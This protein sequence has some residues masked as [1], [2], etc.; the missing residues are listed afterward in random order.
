MVEGFSQDEYIR[1][2]RQ[3]ILPQVGVEGQRKLKEAS[4][5][6]VGAGG[7]G[8]PISLYLAAAGIGRIGLVDPDRVDE[9]NLQRQV[10]YESGMVGQPKVEA[11]RARLIDLNPHCQ[12][13]VF[14]TTFTSATA[15]EIT[16]EFEILVDGSDNLTTRYLMNDLSV[17]TSRAYVF[18]AVQQFE[19]QM[20]L[21]DA[22]IGPCYRC[23]FG[24]PPPPEH[25]PIPGDSGVIGVLPGLVGM[26]QAAETLKFLLGIGDTL[27][28]KLVLINSLTAEFEHIEVQKDPNCPVCGDHPEIKALL[29]YEQHCGASHKNEP[30]NLPEACEITPYELAERLNQDNKITLLDL[31]TTMELEVSHIPGA[32]HF[33]Y[34]R[35]R[36]KISELD[37][38]ADYVLFCRAG[39][40]SVWALKQL[41][42]AGI[43]KV[44]YLM[45]GINAWAE[46]IDSSMKQY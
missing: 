24:D 31:R 33:P 43:N 15:E 6:I 10:I 11:A 41:N 1:Y 39:K 45:G 8:S 29:D 23:I 25:F 35:L 13:D 34:H 3:L 17:L 20:A 2:S 5:L 36:E 27:A 14:Q 46:E 19:G 32:V 21:F 7:L 18:G 40:T 38:E 12:V 26:L 37:Q 44:R 22:R 9:S 28:G 42:K 16:S 30:L 4:V